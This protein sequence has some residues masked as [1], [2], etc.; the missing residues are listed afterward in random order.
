MG[1]EQEPTKIEEGNQ[2]AIYHSK[3]THMTSNL[4]HLELCTNWIKEKAK[5]KTCVLVKVDSTQTSGPSVTQYPH[6]LG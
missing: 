6:S 3:A 5:D 2:A 4:R 1:W